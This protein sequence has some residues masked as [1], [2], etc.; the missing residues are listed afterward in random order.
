MVAWYNSLRTHYRHA[1]GDVVGVKWDL[2]TS[3]GPKGAQRVENGH[4]E[5]WGSAL[6]L[7]AEAD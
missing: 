5:L 6:A 1:K 2:G 7:G 4:I 3:R